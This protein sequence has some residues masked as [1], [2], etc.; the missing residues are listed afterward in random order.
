MDGMFRGAGGMESGL[1]RADFFFSIFVRTV[2]DRSTATFPQE[3]LT[4][5]S[6][7]H[8][9]LLGIEHILG[10]WWTMSAFLETWHYL[11]PPM[12]STRVSIDLETAFFQAYL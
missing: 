1:E 7:M 5:K 3:F 6:Y 11:A 9:S 2:W 8:I 10:L 4:I 12:K